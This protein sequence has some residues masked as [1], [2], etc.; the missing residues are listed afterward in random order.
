MVEEATKPPGVN[1]ERVQDLVE[2]WV[3]KVYLACYNDTY[4]EKLSTIEGHRAQ[5]PLFDIMQRIR[6]SNT[7]DVVPVEFQNR[8]DFVLNSEMAELC[9]D[10]SGR[11]GFSLDDMYVYYKTK[12]EKCKSLKA[13]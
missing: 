4:R 11:Y 8:V 1:R 6:I 12:V 9:R 13:I 10:L 3:P 7:N 5:L 2:L